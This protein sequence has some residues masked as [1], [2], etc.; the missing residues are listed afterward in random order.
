MA[1][2]SVQRL[3]DDRGGELDGASKTTAT[4][5]WLIKVNNKFDTEQTIIN[6]NVLPKL[7][8]PLPENAYLTARKLTIRQKSETPFAWVATAVYSN[9]V[10]N[11]GEGE[12]AQAQQINPV[13][14]RAKIKWGTNQYTRA[15]HR[16]I[17]GNAIVNSAGDYFLDPP[18]EVEYSRWTA[19]IT[20][21]VLQV[22]PWLINYENAVNSAEF[23]V[24]GLTV[25]EGCA[26]ITAI[27]IDDRQTEN[28]IDFYPLSITMEFDPGGFR[29]R[30]LDQGTHRIVNGCDRVKITDKNGVPVDSP[31]LLNGSGGVLA[32]PSPENAV[33]LDFPVYYTYDFSVLPLA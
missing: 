6:A 1:V 19:T 29:A 11:Q 2:V 18:V 33:F 30:P 31:V 4:R 22:P 20:K 15:I 23:E 32:C 21:N 27:S 12:R 28:G 17:Y 24:G 26:R 16:D 7:Y 8:D 14:R 9:E 3:W 13:D 10:E 25:N 5:S